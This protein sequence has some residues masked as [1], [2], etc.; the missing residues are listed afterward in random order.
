M[1]LL[2]AQKWL[3]RRLNKTQPLY[4]VMVQYENGDATEYQL[5]NNGIFGTFP[6]P[7]INHAVWKGYSATRATAKQLIRK[8]IFTEKDIAEV[9]RAFI[10]KK[11]TECRVIEEVKLD[12][13]EAY[14]PR[15]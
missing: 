12:R 15:S 6:T 14:S 4:A 8:T 3:D 5:I 7:L 11:D 10:V 9:T 1:S 13:P 2:D